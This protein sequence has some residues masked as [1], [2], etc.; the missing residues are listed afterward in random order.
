MSHICYRLLAEPG[1]SF[2]T[3]CTDNTTLRKSRFCQ[4]QNYKYPRSSICIEFLKPAV[5]GL[6][7]PRVLI[8]VHKEHFGDFSTQMPTFAGGGLVIASEASYSFQIK[9]A[10]R[11]CNTSLYFVFRLI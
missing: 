4:P 5:F 8:R 7:Y 6:L 2:H 9:S 3:R 11:L 1:G 10:V